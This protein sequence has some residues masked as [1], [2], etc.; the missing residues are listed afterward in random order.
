[1]IGK[2]VSLTILI[3]LVVAG[4][5]VAAYWFLVLNKSSENSDLTGPVP[6]VT[7]KVA[8][9]SSKEA[10]ESAET[11][12]LVTYKNTKVGFQF[13]YPSRFSKATLNEP[14]TYPEVTG[15]EDNVSDIL[16]GEGSESGFLLGIIQS[17]PNTTLDDIYNGWLILIPEEN[18]S[19]FKKEKL[20][21]IGVQVLKII[22]ESKIIS[23]HFL[24]DT[25]NIDLSMPIDTSA[26]SNEEV[27]AI[28]SSFKLL[29]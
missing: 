24:T 15:T 23:V 10:T 4:L 28:I 20:V 26:V 1:M 13:S 16:I 19:S 5:I 8:T 9:E 6:K 12:E 2:K 22:L 29:D 18:K 14:P 11:K 27:E 21:I 25:H 17:G 7:T 3:I